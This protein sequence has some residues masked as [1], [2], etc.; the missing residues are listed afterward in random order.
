MTKSLLLVFLITIAIT[1]SAAEQ[2]PY[3]ADSASIIEAISRGEAREALGALEG[4]ASAAETNAA[5]SPTP[6]QYWF[7]ASNAYREAARAAL[8]SG[9][10][11]KAIAHATK[12]LEIGE[13]LKN[14][15]LQ[16]GA[17]YHIQQAYQGIRDNAKRKEWIERGNANLFLG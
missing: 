10:F 6:T 2:S 17:I 14:P 13:K 8:G 7:E 4:K 3:E 9:Q 15:G 11:Q 5:S 16:A 1:A 12:A